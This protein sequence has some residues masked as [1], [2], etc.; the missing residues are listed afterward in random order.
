MAIQTRR[1]D[2]VN[3]DTV[4]LAVNAAIGDY[5]IS[6]TEYERFTKAAFIY[7]VDNYLHSSINIRQQ[8][9]GYPF[10]ITGDSLSKGNSR[11]MLVFSTTPVKSS[12]TAPDSSKGKNKVSEEN[13]AKRGNMLYPNPVHNQLHIAVQYADNMHYQ[14]RILSA[15][16]TVVLVKEGVVKGG[17]INLATAGLTRGAYIADL[18]FTNGTHYSRQFVKQ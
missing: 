3:R 8:P 9:Q 16:G 7:L 11:F 17:S 5:H 12:T 4:Y 6:F 2:F 13:E 15:T 10:S 14:L 18:R 1:L